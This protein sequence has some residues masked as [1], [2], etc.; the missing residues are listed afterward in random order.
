MRPAPVSV[1]AP[2]PAPASVPSEPASA[3]GAGARDALKAKARPLPKPPPTREKAQAAYAAAVAQLSSTPGAIALRADADAFFE[4]NLE[5][6]KEKA[7]RDGVSL[8]ELREMTHLGLLATRLRQ[9][10]DVEAALGKPLPEGAAARGEELIVQY[11]GEVKRATRDP[12]NRDASPEERKA[13][14]DELGQRFLADYLEL[15]GL[16]PA[17]YDQLLGAPYQ[18]PAR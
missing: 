8:D 16:T 12:A 11:S 13:M 15:T 18:L 5:Q 10:E 1:A 4:F 14:I 17:Q 3:P 2:A 9:W 6:A 7:A